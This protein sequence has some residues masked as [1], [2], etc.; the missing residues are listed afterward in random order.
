VRYGTARTTG[1]PRLRCPS[2]LS[3]RQMTRASA[4]PSNES[5]ECRSG[6]DAVA[7]AKR[8]VFRGVQ[9]SDA[10]HNLAAAEPHSPSTTRRG[11]IGE[12]DHLRNRHAG[13]T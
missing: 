10:L 12:T 5:T 4:K 9:V 3:V 13:F 8:M 1:S 6:R 7:R 2:W 11:E